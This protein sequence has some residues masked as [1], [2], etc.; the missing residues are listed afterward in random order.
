MTTP[1]TSAAAASAITAYGA[2]KS[3]GPALIFTRLEQS[4]RKEPFRERLFADHIRRIMRL[5]HAAKQAPALVTNGPEQ[6]R[7]QPTT[8]WHATCSYSLKGFLFFLK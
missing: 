4:Y 2:G 3:N 7:C 5:R 1:V 6:I 8:H